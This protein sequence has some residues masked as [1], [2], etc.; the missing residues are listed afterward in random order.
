MS[1][2]YMIWSH[3]LEMGGLHLMGN[4]RRVAGK[5]LRSALD[6]SEGAVRQSEPVQ[7]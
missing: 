6:R 7:P 5:S 4:G 1:C 2:N 3:A